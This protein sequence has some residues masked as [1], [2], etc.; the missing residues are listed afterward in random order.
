MDILEN[1]LK[2]IEKGDF[3][4]KELNAAD[5]AFN[6]NVDKLEEMLEGKASAGHVHSDIYEEKN[7][8]I[9]S[10]IANKSN[11]HEV[12]A[13]Q[14]GAVAAAL[15][16]NASTNINSLSQTG[17]YAGV[18]AC[19][20]SQG[21]P[22]D[23]VLDVVMLQQCGVNGGDKT[24]ILTFAHRNEIW[25]R[26]GDWAGVWTQWNAL[27]QN[28]AYIT[29]FGSGWANYPNL[30][31]MKVYRNGSQLTICGC[32]GKNTAMNQFD[33]AFV[34]PIGFRPTE[35][36]MRMVTNTLGAGIRFDILSNGEV[37]FL[38]TVQ[39]T[40]TNPNEFIVFDVSI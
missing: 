17:Y 2:S 4:K 16:L 22:F 13:A 19:L 24:Q 21:Y 23:G 27:T 26:N 18:F 7:S 33:T 14:V 31:K 20:M 35:G 38:Y 10:H 25:H 34:L 9:Q 37:K 30:E 32:I 6:Q 28:M 15:G 36:A 40:G 11:P 29:D 5:A 39:G 12:T 1:R 3:L 8:N